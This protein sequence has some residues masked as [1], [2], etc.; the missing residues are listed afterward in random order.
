MYVC[1]YVEAAAV[2]GTAES[3][4]TATVNVAGIILPGYSNVDVSAENL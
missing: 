1:M 3:S 4:M 2:E